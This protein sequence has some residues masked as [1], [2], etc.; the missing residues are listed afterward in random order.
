MGVNLNCDECG[1][2]IRTIKPQ[3]IAKMR[4]DEEVICDGCLAMIEAWHKKL[5]SAGNDAIAYISQAKAK[6][7]AKFDKV[8][9]DRNIQDGRR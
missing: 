8:L 9:S 5:D 6:A 3:E 2:F 4:H 1:K 7:K